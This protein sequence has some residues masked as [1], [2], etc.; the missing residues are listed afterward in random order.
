M[1][2]TLPPFD[3]QL[4]LPS[5]P[6]ITATQPPLWD[7]SKSFDPKTWSSGATSVTSSS[8]VLRQSGFKLTQQTQGGPSSR[9]ASPGDASPP[10]QNR[11]LAAFLQAQFDEEDRALAAERA[12]LAAAAQRVF[13]CGVCM[14]TL[15]E[16]SIA[17]IE[18][19]G[20]PFCRECV[21]GLI[22]S[23]IESRRFPVLCPTCTAEPGNGS[24]SV[25][26]SMSVSVTFSTLGW[27]F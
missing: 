19:C 5:S 2:W 25:I 26:G 16:D 10:Y 8:F 1:A 24:E 23:K 20:H 14:D 7:F 11:Q 12:E 13:D 17:P 4:A 27:S 9:W 6:T 18:P 21:R 22:V 3:F 15:P